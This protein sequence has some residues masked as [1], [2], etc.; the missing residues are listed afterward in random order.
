MWLD[1]AAADAGRILET[2]QAPIHHAP[3][4]RYIAEETPCS[5]LGICWAYI[6]IFRHIWAYDYI[7]WPYYAIY[8]ILG[9]LFLYYGPYGSPYGPMMDHRPLWAGPRPR[10]MGQDHIYI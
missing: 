2:C 7:F 3:G 5:D 4:L 8:Y 10:A 9:S 1:A 6:Y